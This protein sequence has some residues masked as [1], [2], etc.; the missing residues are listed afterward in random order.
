[1]KWTTPNRNKKTVVNVVVDN[2]KNLK[3]GSILTKK[4]IFDN[5]YNRPGTIEE[6]VKGGYMVLFHT[7]SP[8]GPQGYV[9]KT[10]KVGDKIITYT[11]SVEFVS[12]NEIIRYNIKPEDLKK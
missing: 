1:M 5:N 4:C 9:R 11:G 6:V 8:S 7:S 2:K 10:K 3:V 12:Y